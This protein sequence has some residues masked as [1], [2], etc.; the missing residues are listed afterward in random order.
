MAESLTFTSL[1]ELV[2]GK[3]I[4]LGLSLSE[5]SRKTG[6][7]KG[8]LSKIES[9]ETKRPELRNLK[10]IADGLQ[11]PYDD[12]VELYIEIEHR[13]SILEDF[14]WEAIDISSPS[15]IEK[16]ALK[17][18]EDP[19]KDTFESLEAIFAIANT[20]T[21]NDSRLALYNTIIKYARIHGIPMYIAK[22][23]YQKYLI[24][25]QDLKRMDKS[26]KDGEEI[27]H[28]VDFLSHEDKVTYY[29]KMSLQAY[30]LKK[31]K[32]GIELCLKGLEEDTSTDELKAR[33]YLAM[34]NSMSRLGRYSDVENYLEEFEK[35]NYPFVNEA[36]QL[37][38]AIVKVRKK[39]YSTAI[40]LLE[41]C[42]N[43]ISGESRIHVVN[44]LLEIHLSMNNMD[45]ISNILYR[46]NEYLN[47]SPKTPYKHLSVGRYY[48]YKGIYQMNKKQ[49]EKGVESFIKSLLSF[50]E[51]NA[52][53]EINECMN[54]IISG[55]L[56]CSEPMSLHYLKRLKLVYNKIIGN[57]LM[58]EGGYS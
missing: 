47:L 4:N 30:A 16:V 1:G 54:D 35:F 29:Y 27:L 20:I 15:L 32:A 5:L 50:G 22:G 21:N 55:F 46:E 19:K 43:N 44:E 56:N 18:L 23:L 8:I 24:D 17:F 52:Y 58:A 33:A 9:G 39:E 45:Y 37:T 2:K 26:F 3:R 51:V 48:R 38:R 6:V 36:S 10:L 40:P 12:I 14:L 53:F 28:Y 41:E 49:I 7:S 13:N 42:F 34:I 25:R 11:I 57:R 31:Y